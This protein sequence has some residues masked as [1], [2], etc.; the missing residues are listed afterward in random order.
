MQRMILGLV[1]ALC[2]A[3]NLAAADTAPLIVKD[4]VSNAEIVISP[5]PARTVRLAAEELQLYVKKITGAELPI[6]DH[7]SGNPVIKLYLGESD[8]TKELGLLDTDFSADSYRLVSGT[9]YLAIV[10]DDK[11]VETYQPFPRNGNDKERAQADWDDIS[12]GLWAF[13]GALQERFYNKHVDVAMSDGKGT[14]NGAYDFLRLLGVRWYF[15]GE[16][17]ECVPQ[18]ASI[19]L[20]VVDRSVTPDFSM[21]IMAGRNYTF[22]KIDREQCLWLLRLGLGAPR[23]ISARGHGINNVLHVEKTAEEHPDWYWVKDGKRDASMDARPCLSAQGL[24]D[25]MIKFGRANF[26]VYKLDKFNI[27]PTDGYVSICQC[28]LC[29]GKDTPERGFRGSMSDYVW[30]YANEVATALY[31][32]HPDKM[33][34]CNAYTTYM[35]P[36]LTIDTLSPNMTVMVQQNRYAFTDPKQR[37]FMLDFRDAWMDKLSGTKPLCNHDN[38]SLMGDSPF[39][40]FLPRIIAEDMRSL[41]AIS[42]GDYIEENSRRERGDKIPLSLAINHLN[43]YVTARCWWDAELDVD[44]LLDEYYERFYGPASREMKA[45]IEFSEANWAGMK[46][47]AP[48]IDEALELM[49][50]AKM[51]VGDDT[52]YRER[53]YMMDRY[54]D[55]LRAVRDKVAIGRSQNPPAV[56]VDHSGKELE[57]TLD[58]TIVEDFW[59]DARTYHLHDARTGEK[60]KLDTWFRSV[61]KDDKLYLAVYCQEESGSTLN[62]G[63]QKNEDTAIWNGD[64]VEIFLETQN[65]SYYQIA[66]NPSGAMIDLDQE[67]KNRT[68]W[69]S[70]AEYAVDTGADY[71]SVEMVIPVAD[72]MQSENL[73]DL[74]VSGSK[75]TEDA[76]WHINVGRVRIREKGENQVTMFAVIGPG[77]LFQSP[78]RFCPLYIDK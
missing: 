34:E 55:A 48:L 18:Q 10:G 58:G 25:E 26:D 1:V 2:V 74:M 33:V 60:P 61:W 30:D 49:A 52:I 64:T 77:K 16:F 17:G 78:G 63:T 31:Q 4:G 54:L 39:P 40:I 6:L 22:S 35:M 51:A 66:L 42:H 76:P 11:E 24:R 70:E 75:P 41:K 68:K 62:I 46:K 36:P 29:K 5:Q 32:T 8:Y 9:D 3:L 12:G 73:P 38:Y 27:T 7:P 50:T 15:P 47:E 67:F 21:R 20:P 72:A 19:A 44:A 14:L 69:S 57:V 37:Q 28:D 65:H 13:I 59:K 43:I 56:M 53:V 71:W 23:A 45:L